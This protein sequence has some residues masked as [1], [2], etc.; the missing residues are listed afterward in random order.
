MIDEGDIWNAE[1]SA[2]G[3]AMGRLEKAPQMG[4]ACF[5]FLKLMRGKCVFSVTYKN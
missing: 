1:P 5:S 2:E 4:T 3:M